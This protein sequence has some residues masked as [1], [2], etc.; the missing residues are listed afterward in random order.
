M[1]SEIGPLV[2]TPKLDHR[3]W[4]GSRLAPLLG[5][6]GVPPKLAE[7]WQVHEDNTVAQG[8]FAG[9]TLKQMCER[10]GA[11]LV[12]TEPHRRYGR[13][14]PLLTKLIDAADDL[15][16]QVHPDDAHARR[17][18]GPSAFGK[19]EAWYVLDAGEGASLVHGFARPASAELFRELLARGAAM[20][21]LRRVG[22]RAG[23][24]LL[25]PAGTIH[26]ITAGVMLFEVQQRSDDT[27]RVWDYDRVDADGKRRPLHVEEALAVLHYGADS[28][29]PLDVP[30]A[31][32][33]AT[34]VKCEAFELE[35]LAF[36][37]PLHGTTGPW[38]FQILV[39]A[40]AP[41]RLTWSRGELPLARGHAVVLPASLGAYRLQAM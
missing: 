6:T 8:A 13:C 31:E 20:E 9:S 30:V 33:A 11:D 10:F 7:V 29:L 37:E 26:A 1:S 4:G 19:T 25:V 17:A 35:R 14:F 2:L 24:A 5:L 27:Y 21:I 36:K 12:G 16:I 38:T 15:S 3:L 40:D 41:L 18:S 22:I 32:G 39:A 23:T 34:L 28:P